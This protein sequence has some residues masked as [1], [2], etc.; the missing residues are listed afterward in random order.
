MYTAMGTR[1]NIVFATSTVAQ[2]L[3]NLGWPHWEA[4][5][6]FFHY[7]LGTKDLELTYGGEKRGLVG[8]I[9]ADGASQEHRRAISGYVFMV[10]GGA[11]S[12][13]GQVMLGLRPACPPLQRA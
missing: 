7:L 13:R 5:K 6:K 10:D 1:P 12:V 8:Y 4:V 9:D 3:E 2:F 11:V